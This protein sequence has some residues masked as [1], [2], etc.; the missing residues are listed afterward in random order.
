[1]T[2]LLNLT[3]PELEQF[4]LALGGE[5]FRA[6]QMMKWLYRGAGIP[7]MTNLS[8]AFR[9]KLAAVAYVGKI[10]IEKKFLSKLDETVK[11]LLKLEDGNLIEAVFMKY[12]HGDTVCISTQVGCRMGCRFC[13]STKAGL[14]RDLTAGEMISQIM[15][16]S[17]DAGERISNVVL[18][19]IGEPLDNFDNVVKFLEI[20]NH[21]DGLCIGHR[22]ISLSTCGMADKIRALADMGLQITLSVSLHQTDDAKRSGI[23]PVNKRFHVA[24]LLDACRYYIEK[25]NR[26][27][28]FEYAMIEG[29]TDSPADAKNLGKVLRGML[30]HVNL[31][32]VNDVEGTGFRRSGRQRIQAFAAELQKY[33]VTATVRRE[34]GGDISAS[35]GQLRVNAINCELPGTM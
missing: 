30:C 12:L 34:L 1:M 23:M 10:K 33:G 14:L 2:D 28:S 21:P 26:R 22:H 9:D 32:P 25:T 31:I 8:A 27:V 24:E 35:C 5:K 18:M 3:Y 7:E 15:T 16:V 19:G 4:I 20:V 13:A 6:G 17:A 11:Y 29:V